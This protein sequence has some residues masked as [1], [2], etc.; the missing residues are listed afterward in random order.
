[1]AVRRDVRLEAVPVQRH[2]RAVVVDG[3]RGPGEI[4][5]RVGGGPSVSTLPIDRETPHGYA[6]AA[7]YAASASTS[8]VV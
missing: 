5:A 8:T 3:H 7:A 2:V 6:A 4:A 1:M